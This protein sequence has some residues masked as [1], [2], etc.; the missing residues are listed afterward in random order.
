MHSTIDLW[1][2]N[3]KIAIMVTCRNKNDLFQANLRSFSCILMSIFISGRVDYLIIRNHI[4]S[5]RLAVSL[6]SPGKAIAFLKKKS[7][8]TRKQILG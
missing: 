8:E 5:N 6:T 2:K 4:I 7:H 1:N 3:L